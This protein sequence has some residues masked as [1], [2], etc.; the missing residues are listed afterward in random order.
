[1]SEATPDSRAPDA[2]PG[3]WPSRIRKG[4]V[5]KTTT[6]ASL[7]VAMAQEGRRVLVVDLDPQACLT[8]S[9]GFDPETLED[10]V[11]QVLTGGAVAGDI[12]RGT[13]DVVDLLPATIELATT[14]HLLLTRTGREFLLKTAPCGVSVVRCP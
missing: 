6:V 3:W 4:G 7:R 11:H 5:A 8:F 12:V 14:E 1:M 13:D 2:A 9:L 10:W